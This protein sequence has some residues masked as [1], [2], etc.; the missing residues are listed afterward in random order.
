M[1]SYTIK[2]HNNDECEDLGEY[3]AD[4]LPRVGEPIVLWHPR[5][6]R[7]DDHPFLG[8]VSEVTHEAFLNVGVVDGKVLNESY[9]ET[10]VWLTEDHG[11]PTLYCVCS[12][13]KSSA[14]CEENDG[15]CWDCGGTTKS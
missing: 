9:A 6:S 13:K 15:I 7:D 10:T 5:V 12:P 8:V 14:E 4:Y 2:V 11:T 1:P 3:D